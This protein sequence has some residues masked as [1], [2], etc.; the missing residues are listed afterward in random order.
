MF[1]P[2]TKEEDIRGYKMMRKVLI[3]GFLALLVAGH[4]I[5]LEVTYEFR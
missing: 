2:A 1:N 3:L 5:P 4:I